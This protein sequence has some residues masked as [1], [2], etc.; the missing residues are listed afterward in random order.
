MKKY[1]HFKKSHKAAYSSEHVSWLE[2]LGED[3][4]VGWVIILCTSFVIA[5]VLISFAGWLFYLIESGG[6][7]PS[8][9]VASSVSHA[10]LDQKTLDSLIAGFETKASTTSAIEKGYK[11]PPDPSQ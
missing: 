3:A 6:I 9:S 5:V 7:V 1:F 2:H 4:Y 10:V 8:E 11:G